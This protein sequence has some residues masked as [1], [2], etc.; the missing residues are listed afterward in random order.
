MS[1]WKIAGIYLAGAIAL[2]LGH[3]VWSQ[4]CIGIFQE[5]RMCEIERARD[6]DLRACLGTGRDCKERQGDYPG[7][8]SRR[9]ACACMV[10]Y[11]HDP[12]RYC[13]P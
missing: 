8:C 9:A 2:W 6:A 1:N 12:E 5:R 10:S 7:A 11:G 13:G 4:T 3:Q